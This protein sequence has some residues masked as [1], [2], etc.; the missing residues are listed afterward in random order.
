M[1]SSIL[2][3]IAIWIK[4]N[5][6]STQN[7][8]KQH[9]SWL[10]PSDLELNR[11]RI[12]RDP[13]V[14]RMGKRVPV[15]KSI[16]EPFLSLKICTVWPQQEK[17]RRVLKR[18]FETVQA[19]FI[20][21]CLI[22]IFSLKVFC[23][24]LWFFWDRLCI[25]YCKPVLRTLWIPCSQPQKTITSMYR[26]S[27]FFWIT[28]FLSKNLES[29]SQVTWLTGWITSQGYW[30]QNKLLKT[31]FLS[32]HNSAFVSLFLF[33]LVLLTKVDKDRSNVFCSTVCG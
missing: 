24:M 8:P 6:S 18:T 4:I 10:W 7:T 1:T 25:I 17:K 3:D 26:L 31:F 13:P 20:F 23:L 29:F 22:Y 16:D 28:S 14:T 11:V 12:K 30:C 19:L 2:S 5:C 9:V 33:C 21:C 27:N 32:Q 15:W